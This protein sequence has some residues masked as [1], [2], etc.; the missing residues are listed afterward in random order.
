MLNMILVSITTAL[1]FIILSV[2]YSD[3]IMF[4]EY[5]AVVVYSI[6][7]IVFCVISRLSLIIQEKRIFN[8]VENKTYFDNRFFNRS[9]QQK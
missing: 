2:I 5:L 3:S 7:V 6:I 9:L 1:S 8:H 4:K